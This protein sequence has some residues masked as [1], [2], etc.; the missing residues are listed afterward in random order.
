ML[1]LYVGPGS[2]SLAPHII[3]HELGL[4]HE[5]R[6]VKRGDAAAAAELKS[7]NLMAQVP[8][9]VTEEGY[10]LA[11]GPAI[12][13][14]LVSLKPNSLFPEAGRTRFKAFE[15]M[16][17]ITSALHKGFGPLFHPAGYSADPSHSDAVRAK[18]LESLH[19][20]LQVAEARFSP[21]EFTLGERFTVVD[22]YLFVVL[23]WATPM[24]VDLSGYP[25]LTSFLQRLAKRPSVMA[26]MK[27]EGL[28]GQ[29]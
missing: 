27:A 20:I 9:L 23:S 16:N 25:K 17:F 18:A 26:A 15:W 28:L 5:L 7:H 24:K 29:S 1:K 14:Y 10:D 11:E 6:L 3:I 19:G 2:C 8:T 4:P 21:G 13:Q 12:M 22:A